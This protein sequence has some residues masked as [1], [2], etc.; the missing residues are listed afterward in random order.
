MSKRGP[1]EIPGDWTNGVSNDGERYLPLVMAYNASM[2]LGHMAAYREALKYAFDRQV[3]DIGCGTGYGAFFLAYFGAQHV[4]ALDFSLTALSYAHSTYTH[5]HLEFAQA[6]GL[7]LPFPD[8]SFDFVFSSQVIEHVS[9]VD[10]FLCEIRRVLRPE[11]FCMI[12]TPNKAIFSPGAEASNQFHI[13]EM[14]VQTFRH[15]MQ[16]VFP[17]TRQQGIP[18][19][20]AQW[21]ETAQVLRFKPDWEV[22][23]ADFCVQDE[24]L[25]AC[26]NMLGFGHV[27]PNGE[28]TSRLPERLNLLVAELE[29]F[30][31]DAQSDCWPVLGLAAETRFVAPIIMRRGRLV[32]RFTAPRGGLYR[33]QLSFDSPAPVRL[34]VSLAAA[35]Q[36]GHLLAVHNIA[37]GE[38]RLD[39][40]LPKAQ[41]SD[42]QE[43]QL[44]IERPLRLGDLPHF[45]QYAR[46][47]AVLPTSR[48]P[49]AELNGILQHGGLAL[50]TFHAVL[51]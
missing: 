30:F 49:A 11:G 19:R 46:F 41:D 31:W 21:D 16:K 32:Q 29:P 26:E 14:D 25:E 33:L 5:P 28:F 27:Q 36:P 1:F 23:P 2:H 8:K 34:R 7:R 40:L 3:L 12:T 13:S 39:W 6:D 18:Q 38:E 50:R 51:P 15:E 48:V 17:H 44:V 9:S 42:G 4:T 22:T 35:E 47:S 37:A 43:Y 20:C 24:D 45:F 10:E